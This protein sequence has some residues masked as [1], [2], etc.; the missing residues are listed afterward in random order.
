M[1]KAAAKVTLD[2]ALQI[3]KDIVNDFYRSR[4]L[5]EIAVLQ[6]KVDK[7]AA[8][9][10]FNDAIQITKDIAEDFDRHALFIGHDHYR[11]QAL[12]YR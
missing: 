9:N 4:A 10:T 7:D 5:A 3:A 2:T 1:D 8:K 6:A 12:P 11:L